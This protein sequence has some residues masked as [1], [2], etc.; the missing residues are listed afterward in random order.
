MSDFS[1]LIAHQGFKCSDEEWTEYCW[2]G[3]V[4]KKVGGY[5]HG[6]ILKHW[7]TSC[8]V[9]V[10]VSFEEVKR[11]KQKPKSQRST[12]DI[13]V[14]HEYEL[15]MK[16]AVRKIE[17]AR[18]IGKKIRAVNII[19]QKWF[20]YMYRPEGITAKQ[21][22]LHYQLLWTVREEMRQVNNA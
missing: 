14:L 15:W 19:S 20:E 3:N 8:S 17:R 9:Y 21:L 7:I 2:M 12:D 11:L 18:E 16:N 5:N 13:Y 6:G 4:R 1:S 10:H 22:A